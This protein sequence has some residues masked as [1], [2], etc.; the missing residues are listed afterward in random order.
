MLVPITSGELTPKDK[1]H[2]NNSE[3]VIVLQNDVRST[4][5]YVEIL[6]DSLASVSIIHDS[7]I[8]MCE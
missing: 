8:S 1:I 2:K 6:I 5:R 3:N 4:S 7:F